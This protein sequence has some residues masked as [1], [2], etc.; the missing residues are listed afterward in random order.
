MNEFGA[1]FGLLQLRQ[2]DEQIEKRKAIDATYRKGLRDI[3]GIRCHLPSAPQKI[4]YSYFPIFV[5]DDYPLTRDQL[6]E[7]LKTSGISGRRYFYPLITEFSM[8]KKNNLQT[9]NELPSAQL[10]AERV[11]CLPIYPSLELE[12]IVSVNKI[13]SENSV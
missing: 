8:Y 12:D 13:I 1:A 4:N 3:P 5:E 11:I 6:Y 9:H 10:A 7:K 2:I